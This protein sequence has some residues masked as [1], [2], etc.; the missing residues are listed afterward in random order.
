MITA[1]FVYRHSDGREEVRYR[2]PYGTR[3]T[4]LMIEEVYALQRKAANGGWECPYFWRSV[5][6]GE[7]SK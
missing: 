4:E 7:Q 2:R 1:E 6:W 3:S 5:G